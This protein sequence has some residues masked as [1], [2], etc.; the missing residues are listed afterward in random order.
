MKIRPLENII[1]LDEKIDA[2]ANP[3]LAIYTA[4]D[5]ERNP[6]SYPMLVPQVSPNEI[7]SKPKEQQDILGRPAVFA[8]NYGVDELILWPIPDKEYHAFFEFNPPRRR[9]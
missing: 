9:I 3:L 5:P 8:V 7:F 6:E 1:S 4:G 2:T